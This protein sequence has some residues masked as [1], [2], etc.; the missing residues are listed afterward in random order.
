MKKISTALISVYHKEGLDDILEVLHR[1]GCRFISTGGTARYIENSGYEVTE[2]TPLTGYPSILG[3]RV[4][5][6]HPAVFGGILARRDSPDDM[7]TLRQYGI[8]PVD[9]VIV[10]LYPFEN[11]VAQ[12]ASHDDIIEKIDIGGIS[13]IRA[14]AKNYRDVVCISHSGQYASFAE[15]LQANNG[16]TPLSYRKELA[17]E[18]FAVSSYYDTVISRYFS[19]LLPEAEPVFREAYSKRRKLRYGENPHQQGYFFGDLNGIFEQLHGKE[20]SYNNLLDVDAA[21]R[22]IEDFDTSAPVFGIFK[23]NNACGLSVRDTVEEAYLA[24]LEAD[25][26]SAFGGVLITNYPVDIPAAKAMDSLF[27]EILIAP[28]FEPGAME[29]LT[30]KKK[31]I[32]L[33]KK[34]PLRDSGTPA[35]SYR[36]VLNGVLYQE[37]D[38]VT[39]S[40]SMLKTVTEKSPATAEINDMLFASVIAKHSKSN[41]MV[42]AKD[43]RMIAAGVGQ[44]SR[45]DALKQ[46]IDKARHFGL[47]MQ[48]AVLASDAF[49][50]FAD[51]AEIAYHAGIR[52][53]IQP[54]GSIRDRETIAYCNAHGM[55]MVFTGHRHFKH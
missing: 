16:Q 34:R 8:P 3:G 12:A 35:Y 38:N 4:K 39:D 55:A 46:A 10:D 33:R 19:G 26:V 15:L 52:A 49:L 31:R 40:I 25:P 53:I 18:A 28:D 7:D 17:R 24:A 45:V 29:I 36:S 22:L 50:P 32:L 5:T 11:T 1:H 6:L 23:H 54:G 27:F 51:S 9:L 14:A 43:R 20:L 2:T 47:D 30:R 21:V 44:T 13:L 37:T 48:G 41:A 42:L